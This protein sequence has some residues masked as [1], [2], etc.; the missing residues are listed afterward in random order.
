[1]THAIRVFASVPVIALTLLASATSAQNFPSRPVRIVTSE[2]GGL[3]DF[4]ARVIAQSLSGPLGK[5][6]VVENRG[7]V[8]IDIV[9]KASPDGHTVLCFANNFWLLQF[10]QEKP[11]FNPVSDFSPITLAVTAP[12]V[13]A[14]NASVRAAT[15]RELIALAKT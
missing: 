10:L 1:V 6:V 5:P 15:P 3:N 2:V 9:A 13:L 14:I 11:A 7:L 8:A 4:T 12:N